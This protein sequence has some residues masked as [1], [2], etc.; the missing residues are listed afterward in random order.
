MVQSPTDS[1]M[2]WPATPLKALSG[3]GSTVRSGENLPIA[4]ASFSLSSSMPRSSLSTT[5]LSGAP[6]SARSTASRASAGKTPMITALPAF[7]A[8]PTCSWMAAVSL[9]PAKWPTTAPAAAPTATAPSIGGANRPTSTPAAAA[10]PG[11]AAAEV[12]AGVHQ[13]GLA[14]GPLAHQDDALARH[15]LGRH[16][17]GER[18]EL[19]LGQVDVGVAGHEEHLGSGHVL[20]PSQD[21]ARDRR[22]C[23]RCSPPHILAEWRSFA[24]PSVM[25]QARWSR[26]ATQPITSSA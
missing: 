16:L 8:A 21:V 18:A 14:V 2:V 22:T 11:A 26:R 6:G 10:P 20:I 19:P 5:D 23:G 1:S 9:L 17:V 7:S 15:L 13:P 25:R 4:S 24:G 12:V 3:M